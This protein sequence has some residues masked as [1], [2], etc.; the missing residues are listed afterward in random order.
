VLTLFDL[1]IF[2]T[3]QNCF[4]KRRKNPKLYNS[5][6]PPCCNPVFLWRAYGKS[7]VSAHSKQQQ[8]GFFFAQKWKAAFAGYI[9]QE[10]NCF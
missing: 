9:A 5:N 10:S 1:R 6:I 7:C 2:R 8:V 3:C 4:I